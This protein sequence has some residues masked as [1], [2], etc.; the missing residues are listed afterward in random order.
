MRSPHRE[1]FPK[2]LFLLHTLQSPVPRPLSIS[3]G[4]RRARAI[5]SLCK[6]SVSSSFLTGAAIMAPNSLAKVLNWYLFVI[7]ISLGIVAG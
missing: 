3:T 2:A 6:S 1:H 7:T 5:V 4:G